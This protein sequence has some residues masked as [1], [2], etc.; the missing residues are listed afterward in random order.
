MKTLWFLI[1]INPKHKTVNYL[2]VFNFIRIYRKPHSSPL[3]EIEVD[4]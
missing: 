4:E 2:L 1:F 3:R